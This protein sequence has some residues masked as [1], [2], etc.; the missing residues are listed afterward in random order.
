M[1]GIEGTAVDY[2]PLE[3]RELGQTGLI[4]SRLCFGSLTLGPL[5]AGLEPA[6]GAALLRQALEMGVRFIDSAEQYRTY[7][8]IRA[9]LEGFP[10]AK[11]VVIASK[12]LAKTDLEAAWAV[13]DA[14][15]A[16]GRDR[17]D[18]MLLH[19]VRDD[20]DFQRRAGAWRVLREA[21]ANGVIRAIGISTHSAALAAQAAVNR[22]IDV[23]HP[24]LNLAGIGI[25][26]GGPA[27][28]LTAIRQAKANGK[29]V[30]TM[31]ALGGG[32]LMHQARQALLWAFSQPEADAVAVGCKD[33]A[34]LLTNIGWLRGQEPPQAAQVR[35]LERRMVFD[36]EPR[37]HGCGRCV[38]RCHS[39]AMTLDEQGEACWQQSKCLYCG[40]CIAACPWFCLSFC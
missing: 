28:M 14:R 3:L 33:Q 12:T 20:N 22:R 39:G 31:K 24:L 35:L 19:D 32:A 2:Q 1:D 4:V 36:K 11:Q 23:I 15:I 27:E 18:I 34:E 26:D 16:L 9:A 8:Y 38:E 17:L 13:E 21:K 7:P 37:C 10:A 30:Y 29:G 6:A 40:Y 25:L 5:C